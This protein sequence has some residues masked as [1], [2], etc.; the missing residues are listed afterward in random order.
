MDAGA[1]WQQ[2]VN[3]ALPLQACQQALKSGYVILKFHGHFDRIA[4]FV[5]IIQG[6][7]NKETTT[8]GKLKTAVIGVGYLG[9]F[10]AEKYAAHADCDLVAVVD[11]NKDTARE[12][13]GKH[14]VQA[15]TDYKELLGRVDAVSIATPTSVH[16]EIARSFLEN[17]TH[18]LIEKPMT[19]TVDEA[20]DLIELAM[21]KDRLIQV[22]HMERFNAAMMDIDKILETPTFIE[23][24]RLAPFNPRA[25]DVN[26]VLDLMIHDIDIILEIVKSEI[27]EMRASG[28]DVLTSSTDIANARLEFENGCVANV[29]AS[30]VSAKTER[31]IRIFQHNA[32]ISVDFHN[33]VLTIYR[34][35][36][37]EMHPGIPEIISEESAY[38][39]S[40][41]L[42]LEIVAFIDS[43]KNG[44]PVIVSG[45]D[46]RRA[47]H[48]AVRISTLLN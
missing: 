11:T 14:G 28:T 23:S 41:A 17:G 10:H 5:I 8:M 24:H 9:K 7:S 13:A 15:L 33:R 47:L 45:E 30:R 27:K 21:Q 20:D 25:T 39:N 12:I 18:V 16:H 26:V 1:Q 42:N 38:E 40:D 29:T 36:S 37:K 43:I 3:P 22:G 48:T 31:K 6:L 46:G 19:V 4:L 32:Y 2:S 34:K 35:G 44:T